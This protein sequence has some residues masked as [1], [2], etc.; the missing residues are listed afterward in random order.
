[1]HLPYRGC[2]SEIAGCCQRSI[3]APCQIGYLFSYEDE[4]ED[5]V[6]GGRMMLRRKE[7]LR[8]EARMMLRRKDVLICVKS[9]LF[10]CKKKIALLY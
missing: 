3:G 9:C 8:A 5:D 10:M 1:M 4:D 6:A 2:D 7:M